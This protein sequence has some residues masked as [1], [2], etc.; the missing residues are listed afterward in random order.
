VNVDDFLD[1]RAQSGFAA[2]LQVVDSGEVAKKLRFQEI[3]GFDKTLNLL[4][5][6]EFSSSH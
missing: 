6:R 3:S 4:S 1:A 2:G 5:V